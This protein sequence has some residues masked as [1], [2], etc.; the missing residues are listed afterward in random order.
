MPSVFAAK[1]NHYSK[2]ANCITVKALS[3]III[4]IFKLI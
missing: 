1:F 3:V 4:A 2:S